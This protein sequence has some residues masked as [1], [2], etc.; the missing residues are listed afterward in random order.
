MKGT[1]DS[2]L[3]ALRGHFQGPPADHG[4]WSYSVSPVSAAQGTGIMIWKLQS[5]RRTRSWTSRKADL[6]CPLPCPKRIPPQMVA[7]IVVPAA[8]ALHWDAVI[9]QSLSN[10]HCLLKINSS[11]SVKCSQEDTTPPGRGLSVRL[12]ALMHGCDPAAG[13]P[14]LLAVA[15]PSTVLH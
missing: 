2:R 9:E 11:C 15:W 4:P 13:M 10:W 5:S 3:S 6:S 12:A 1:V 7:F 14:K 8:V